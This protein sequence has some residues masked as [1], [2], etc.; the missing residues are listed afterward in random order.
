[1]FAH[2]CAYACAFVDSCVCVC[3]CVD[4]YTLSHAH[5]IHTHAFLYVCIAWGLKCIWLFFGV[6]VRF[7]VRASAC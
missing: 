4:K 3:V 1:M 6:S 2:A 7:Y 5:T